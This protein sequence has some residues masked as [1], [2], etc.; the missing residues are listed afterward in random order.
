MLQAVKVRLYPNSEQRRH[1]AQSF[2]CARWYWN[3]SLALTQKNYQETAKGLSRGAIQGLLP[4]L[5]KEY[6]WLTEPYSQCLQVVALNLSNAFINFFEGRGKFPR[7]KAKGNKQSISYPQNVKVLDGYIKFPKLKLVEAKISKPIEG[8][9]KTVTISQVPSGKYYASILVDDGVDTPEASSEGKC[10]GLDVGISEICVTS[11]GSKYNNPR[12]F[13]K[14]QKN[15]KRKQQKLARKQLGSKNRYKARKLAAKVYE[16]VSNCR[17]DFLHKLSRRI[18]DEN[19]VIAVENLNVKGMVKNPKLALAISNVGWGMLNTM[20]KYKA[21]W[22]GKVYMQIDRFFPSSKL[23]NKCLYQI[24]KLPLDVR[25]W[26]CP[27]CG[28]KHIDRDINTAKNIR[29]EALRLLALGRKATAHG[30]TVR[31]R[32]GREKSTTEQVLRK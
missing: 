31:L 6:E 18:V 13:K 3:Y 4:Q 27:K 8:T 26:D 11:E 10:I 23:H 29:D 9:V 2:G 17:L 12:W 5:K 20:L 14:H 25:F 16:K 28:E 19:Q 21:E 22:S 1:L 7:F 30:G 15:L 32:S 24:D